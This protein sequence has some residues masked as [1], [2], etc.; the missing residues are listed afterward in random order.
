MAYFPTLEEARAYRTEFRTVPVA[1]TV[2]SD[3][4]TPVEALRILK[5][6]SRHCFILES[7]EDTER[8]HLSLPSIQQLGQSS[9][10]VVFT[11]VVHKLQMAC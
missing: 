4:R 3:S 6:V 1:R 7:L 10:T 8:W 9:H 2:L 5:S 11:L